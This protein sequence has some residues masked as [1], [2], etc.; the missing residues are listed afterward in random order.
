MDILISMLSEEG[1]KWLNVFYSENGK[2]DS[3]QQFLKILKDSNNVF[4]KVEFFSL[5]VVKIGWSIREIL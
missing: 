5:W 2:S 3:E 1:I 4:I